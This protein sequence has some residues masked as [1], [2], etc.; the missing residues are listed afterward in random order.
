MNMKKIGDIPSGLSFEMI[1]QSIRFGRLIEFVFLNSKSRK[2]KIE[3]LVTCIERLESGDPCEKF[4]IKIKMK[5][6]APGLRLPHFN[7]EWEGEYDTKSKIGRMNKNHEL[8]KILR[9]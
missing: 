4:R 8:P 2:I 9:S 5:D 3:G 1:M 6:P 7:D